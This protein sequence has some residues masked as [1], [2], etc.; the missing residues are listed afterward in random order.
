M[1]D[2]GATIGV[3]CYDEVRGVYTSPIFSK[4]GNDGSSSR[5]LHLGLDLFAPPGTPVLAPLDGRVHS[6]AENRNPLDYGPT[7]ILEHAMW[8]E[9]PSDAA[10]SHPISN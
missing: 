8:A 9:R 4:P 3:G 7:V 10:G 2:A 5:T 6:I 1:D